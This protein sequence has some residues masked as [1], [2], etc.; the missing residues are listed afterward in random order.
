MKHEPLAS[1]LNKIRDTYIA[2]AA[3]GR[4]KRKAPWLG[5]IAALLVLALGLSIFALTAPGQDDTLSQPTLSTLPVVDHT[6]YL[7][8]AP[9]YPQI[10][11]YPTDESDHDGYNAWWEDQR[12]LRNHP[13]GYAD[14]LHSYFAHIIP[15][16]LTGHQGENVTCSPL[17]L[18]MAMAMLA[19]TTGGESRQ[20]ILNLLQVDG[21]EALRTQAGQ[22]WKAHYNNDGLSTS[23]LGSSLWLHEDVS[24]NQDTVNTLANN[25]YASV[26]QGKLGTDE[27]NGAL[28]SWLNE[29]TGG[30]LQGYADK[31]TLSPNTVLAIAT[32]VLYQV[33]WQDEFRQENNS[34]GIFH[35]AAG[36]T[37]ETFMNRTLSY[38]PY[39][40]SDHFGAVYLYLEDGSRMWLLLPDKGMT[41]EAILKSGEVSRFF[42][43][44]QTGERV[45]VEL[46]VPKFDVASDM[47]LTEVL[48]E[49]GIRD[50]FQAGT[51]DF[52]PLMTNDDGGYVD[53]VRHATR[54][55][56]DEKGVTAAAFTVIARC[57]AGIPPEEIIHFTLDR[58][59]IFYIESRDGLP[60]FTG[61]VNEP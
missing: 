47:D 58:P 29:Q 21:I 48:K 34:Q 55:T 15:A 12:E 18:Y 27:M 32:T 25:Y 10:S 61:I 43:S 38:G 37:E 24:Y 53:Q 28:R 14:N 5:A 49:L 8:A 51:A 39:Y 35:G 42:S 13:E 57:G 36:D 9:E 54:V 45:I 41:P 20:Q 7:L 6:G 52:S 26:F 30:L 17:N 2:E 60:L 23:V 22:V 50:V 11:T 16:L 44:E 40:R 31:V 56:I 46:S 4:K 19:E 33:Q 3:V 1:A 59:F